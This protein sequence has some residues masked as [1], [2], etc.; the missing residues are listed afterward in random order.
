MIVRTGL[1]DSPYSNVLKVEIKEELKGLSVKEHPTLGPVIGSDGG[2]IM[3]RGWYHLGG[4]KWTAAVNLFR[5]GK[6]LSGEDSP[7]ASLAADPEMQSA[8]AWDELAASYGGLSPIYIYSLPGS[9]TDR[10][11]EPAAKI[12][13]GYSN[14][15]IL[16]DGKA[17][18]VLSDEG[19]VLVI[20]V[21]DPEQAS[22]V[23]KVEV[24]RGAFTGA[25]I[26]DG[27]IYASTANG[28]FE[29]EAATGAAEIVSADKGTAFT[30][31][32][33]SDGVIYISATATSEKGNGPESALFRI[34]GEK[35]EK[36]ADTPE[37][38]TALKEI[39]GRVYMLAKRGFYRFSEDATRIDASHRSHTS[40]TPVPFGAGGRVFSPQWMYM[41]YS[42][43]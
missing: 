7:Y 34:Q 27:R 5:E 25:V 36:L 11:V 14:D 39:Y 18:Y 40:Y 30:G 13:T 33:A 10:L 9:S 37:P 12:F 2:F 41:E 17:M 43:L 24:D 6:A 28:V 4:I 1:G 38:A 26:L 32:T 35:I 29:I 20:D 8:A 16:H 19:V 31:L 23:R 3:V 22:V 42:D 15:H 21:S